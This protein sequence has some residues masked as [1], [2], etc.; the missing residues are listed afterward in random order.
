MTKKI[1]LNPVKKDLPGSC[2]LYEQT[3]A[4]GKYN[5]MRS[6]N[7]NN[8]YIICH[9]NYRVYQTTYDEKNVTVISLIMCY[10]HNKQSC[11]GC[12]YT[13]IY[14]TL[15]SFICI[16]YLCLL[17]YKISYHNKT[18]CKTR[19]YNFSGIG[20]PEALM[21]FMSSNGLAK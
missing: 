1:I 8:A 6:G 10:E 17:Q 19:F 9:Q 16:N 21:N 4:Q 18:F 5:V 12:Y 3:N 15:D 11:S 14:T 13:F 2:W 7:Q 20:I